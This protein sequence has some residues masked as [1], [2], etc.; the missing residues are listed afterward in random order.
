[1]N[2]TE[3]KK[4]SLKTVATMFMQPI[5]MVPPTK[6][7]DIS[8]HKKPSFHNIDG[9]I[10]DIHTLIT[11]LEHRQNEKLDRLES[12]MLAHSQSTKDQI[13]SLSSKIDSMQGGGFKY[14]P[15]HPYSYLRGWNIK[16]SI[17]YFQ[18]QY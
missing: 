17:S 11:D 9:D 2:N 7:T 15:Y 12:I 5:K 18:Y 16:N 4:K 13:S 14:R 8:K 10:G 6:L 1:M 3:E